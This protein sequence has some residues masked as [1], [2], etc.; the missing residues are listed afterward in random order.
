MNNGSLNIIKAKATHV[1]LKPGY[2]E[3]L[4]PSVRRCYDAYL[5]PF[6]FKYIP[7]PAFPDTVTKSISLVPV[8]IL[9]DTIKDGN[10][11][12]ISATKL[13]AINES[14]LWTLYFRL[15]SPLSGIAS[16]MYQFK[17][18]VDSVEY[19]SEPFLCCFDGTIHS[20][21]SFSSAFSSAFNV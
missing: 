2:F 8:S 5:I 10:E 18:I 9:G 13:K 16:G 12:E 17:I 1:F 15:D 19:R 4:M 3:S 20:D 14:N 21:G 7:P 11:I 6:F